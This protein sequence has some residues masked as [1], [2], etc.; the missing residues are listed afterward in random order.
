M[1]IF[2]HGRAISAKKKSY[3]KI[4]FGFIEPFRSYC[5]NRQKKKKKKKKIIEFLGAEIPY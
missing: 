2:V 3:P 1:P 5:G 4:W